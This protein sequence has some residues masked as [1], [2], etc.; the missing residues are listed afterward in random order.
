VVTGR[1][2]MRIGDL[3]LERGL[4]TP[5]QIEVA[6]AEQ[7]RAYR[8]LGAILLSL[9]FV[10][11]A[12]VA[13]L[14]S[15]QLGLPL[16]DA[17]SARPDPL[18][19]S[20]ISASFVREHGALPIAMQ[21]DELLVAMVDPF[22]PLR[23]A[24]LREHF[25]LPLALAV[26]PED[27]LSKLVREF[28]PD[29]SNRVSELLG[30]LEAGA[31]RDGAPIEELAQALLVD[32]IL[33]GATDVHI[34]PE[35]NV[36]RVRY[37][38]DGILGS[39]ENLPRSLVDALISRVKIMAR[40]D[41]S[42]RRRPQDGRI[43]LK[44]DRKVFDLRVSTRP[45]AD[46][47][48]VVLRVLDRSS[49]AHKLPELGFGSE[50]VA[51]MERVAKRP[52]GLFLVTGP[53]GSGKTTTLYSLL[54]LVD[55]MRLN[56]ATIED[57]IEYRMPLVRQ[58]Q[59]DPAVGFGFQ[60][61]L[62]ALLRQDPDVILVGEIRDGDTAQMAVRASMTGH[63]V[64]STLHTNSAI[65][66]V[67]RLADL[68]VD[69]FLV[70]DSLIGVLAQRLVRRLCPACSAPMVPDGAMQAWLGSDLGAPRVPVGCARCAQTGYQ[71]RLAV[72]ELFLPDE[73]M[74]EAL[75]RGTELPTLRRLALEGGFVPL[76]EDGKRLVRAG[77]TSMDEVERTCRNH[78]F[79]TRERK[80]A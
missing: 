46:G 12:S 9:G 77:M 74:E 71:G 37:R 40:L 35:E 10:D 48:N 8:P 42:E 66:A 15:E 52:H 39:G 23:V 49:G 18:L 7:K 38:V 31:E 56:V 64:L 57:P 1:P 67:P 2:P 29:K 51:M 76:E 19:L 5:Q 22:D 41:I 21:G 33:R 30:A 20:M 75:R 13:R 59:V 79:A 50:T 4:I 53:T 78:R 45:V 25:K 28:L 34:E 62:R 6:L 54:S 26:I 16:L 27:E 11:S 58:S 68:G 80:V 73:R 63:L 44:I 72:S 69:T 17:T 70:E 24:E 65:G 3:L 36:A 47:E 55:A 60:E 32:G 14:L 43:R 61:G